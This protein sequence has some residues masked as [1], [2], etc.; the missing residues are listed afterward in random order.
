MDAIH[1][2]ERCD[3]QLCEVIIV[4][5]GSTDAH[6]VQL[7][8]ELERTGYQVINQD[9]QGL[10]MARNSGITAAKGKYILPLDADNRIRPKY[11]SE[12]VTILDKRREAGVVYG[13][14]EY[15]G[16]REGLWTIPSFDFPRLLVGNFIDACAVYRRRIWEELGGY[17]A[18]MPAMGLEDWEFWIRAAA[19][20]WK[21]VHINEVLFD[22]RV[23]SQS[24]IGELSQSQK[25][26]E[27]YQYIYGKHCMIIR[28][29]LKRLYKQQRSPKWLIQAIPRVLWKRLRARR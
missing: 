14:A 24:M 1:S 21:F 4:N 26:Q 3:R 6:T 12:S 5:D 7:T 13:N 16:E 29:E 18:H 2:V 23:R 20:G 10:A 28:D 11:I 25:K 15:F 9:N 17:D 19:L 8:R 27:C 22:Y